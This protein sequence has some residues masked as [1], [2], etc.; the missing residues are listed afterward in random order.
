V[1]RGFLIT[2]Y[3][4]IETKDRRIVVTGRRGR[5]RKKLLDDVKEKRAYWKLKKRK[6]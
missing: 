3:N 4:I 1:H 6:H 2:L 5:T